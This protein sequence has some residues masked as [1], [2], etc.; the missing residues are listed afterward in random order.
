MT[1][2]VKQVAEALQCRQHC[3]LSLIRSGSLRASNIALNPNGKVRWRIL[4]E[5]LEAFLDRRR[6][7]IAGP[8][9][10]KRKAKNNVIQY[11]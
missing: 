3:V 11:F 10:K 5:D 8:R 9:P 6:L 1:L 4:E 2:T 7:L